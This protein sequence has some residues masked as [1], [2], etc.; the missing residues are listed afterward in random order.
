MY[1]INWSHE[2][3]VC[4]LCQKDSKEEMALEHNLVT[5]KIFNFL[6]TKL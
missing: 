6:N 5:F 3:I 2:E 4:I 1:K